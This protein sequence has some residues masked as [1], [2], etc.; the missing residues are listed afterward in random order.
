MHLMNSIWRILLLR[1]TDNISVGIEVRR[2]VV[3]VLHPDS[4]RGCPAELGCASVEGHHQEINHGLPLPVQT[5]SGHYVA[6]LVDV[7]GL[8]GLVAEEFVADDGVA[9]GI[10]VEGLE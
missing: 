10:A 1:H 6:G 8:V 2:A 7:E 3:Y 5:T 9:A 4:D